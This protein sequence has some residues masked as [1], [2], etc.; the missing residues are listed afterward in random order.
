M[1]LHTEKARHKKI[2]GIFPSVTPSMSMSYHRQ[3]ELFVIVL[4]ID[5]ILST[6]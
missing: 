3:R 6:N 5:L 4:V 2:I 1:N